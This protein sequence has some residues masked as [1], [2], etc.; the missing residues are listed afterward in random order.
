[1]PGISQAAPLI[2]GILVIDKTQYGVSRAYRFIGLVFLLKICYVSDVSNWHIGR[3]AG[4][5]ARRGHQIDIITWN[6]EINPDLKNFVSES[7]VHV[8]EKPVASAGM[9]GRLKNFSSMRG[10]LRSVLAE[11]NPDIV[12]AH[13]AG[14]Y[15]WMAM[16]SGF[17][18]Y[19]VTPWG[20][21][22]FVD[23]RRSAFARIM[24]GLALRRATLVTTDGYHVKDVLLRKFR[25]KPD[26]LEVVIFGVDL[27]RFEALPEQSAARAGLGIRDGQ[28]VIST[29]TLAPIHDVETFVRAM[30][31]IL[32]GHPRTRFV[33][34]GDGVNKP[35]LVEL[36]NETGVA[37]AVI[38]TG[39]VDPKTV[40]DLLAASDVYVSSS[41]SD[42]GL[43]GSTAEAMACGLPV[44]HAD[45]ADNRF[46]ASGGDG[47]FVFPNGDATELAGHVTRLLEDQALRTRAGSRNRSVIAEQYN[48]DVEMAKME[49][50]YRRVSTAAS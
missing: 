35:R 22:I 26:R 9:V 45:N 19:V 32:K 29:R 47:G 46:W 3:W 2:S 50:I 30:P 17:H 1:M 10:K 8:L 31:L 7:C 43:A 36:A 11:I 48:Y 14:S 4:F 6:P 13:T 27:R 20:D 18:P 42:A 49:D 44:V 23:A 40:V 33:V 25:V 28:I 12:H 5:F 24:T 41:V 15:A 16:L 38:F 39:R 37:N 34:V 21:D